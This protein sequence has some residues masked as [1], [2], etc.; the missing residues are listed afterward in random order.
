MDDQQAKDLGLWCPFW[1]SVGLSLE[2]M[3]CDV[4]LRKASS[5]ALPAGKLPELPCVCGCDCRTCKRAWWAAG[6]PSRKKL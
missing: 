2:H 1:G 6:R 5:S 4:V 3:N